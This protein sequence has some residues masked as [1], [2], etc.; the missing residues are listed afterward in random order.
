MYHV[1]LV[2]R[3][4]FITASW[5][6]SVTLYFSCFASAKP[7]MRINNKQFYKDTYVSQLTDRGRFLLLDVP[8]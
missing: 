8:F 1:W 6:S 3:Y 5:M 7:L 2:H 4:L